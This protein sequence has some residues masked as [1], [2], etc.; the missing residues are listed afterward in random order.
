VPVGEFFDQS[1]CPRPHKS[2]RLRGGQCTG[3]GSRGGSHARGEREN[4]PR[5]ARE[6]G[7]LGLTAEMHCEMFG[8]VGQAALRVAD[9]HPGQSL[10]VETGGLE[11][12]QYAPESLRTTVAAKYRHGRIDPLLKIRRPALLGWGQLIE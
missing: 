11:R 5:Q 6:L 4:G 10:A 1:V 8:E 2:A 7:P 3:R 9:E 12:S